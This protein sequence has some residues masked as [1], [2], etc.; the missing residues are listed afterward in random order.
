MNCFIKKIARRT[1]HNPLVCKSA[2]LSNG[3]N[4]RFSEIEKSSSDSSLTGDWY[5]PGEREFIA[6]VLAVKRRMSDE[7]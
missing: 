4:E 1:Q 2:C 5:L 6:W 7:T 3:T